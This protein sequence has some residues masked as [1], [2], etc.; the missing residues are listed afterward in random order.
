MQPGKAGEY[1]SCDGN[2][3]GTKR[4]S[5]VEMQFFMLEE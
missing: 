1:S 3:L 5:D 2:R 4:D